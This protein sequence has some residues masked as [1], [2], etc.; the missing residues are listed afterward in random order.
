[1]LMEKKQKIEQ[2]N[3]TETRSSIVQHSAARHNTLR[4]QATEKAGPSTARIVYF[5]TATYF[6]LKTDVLHLRNDE[7]TRR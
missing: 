6:F 3:V 5:L 7:A 2:E 4:Q 1:M